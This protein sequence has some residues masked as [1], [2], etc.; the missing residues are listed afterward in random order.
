M[1]SVSFRVPHPPC[2]VP[3]GIAVGLDDHIRKIVK[4]N[5]YVNC[6]DG[7]T[8]QPAVINGCSDLFVELWGDNGK[9]ARAAIGVSGL[10]AG[11]PVEIEAIFEIGGQ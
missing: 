3:C 9:H 8:D 4:I 10:P 6:I 1:L 5:G 11:V 2:P 7:F